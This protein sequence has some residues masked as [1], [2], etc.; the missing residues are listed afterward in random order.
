M[1]MDDKIMDHSQKNNIQLFD[2]DVK[3]CKVS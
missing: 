1:S 2:A 3:N